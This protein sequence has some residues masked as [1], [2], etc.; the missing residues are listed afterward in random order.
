MA[1]VCS[2]SLG[3]SYQFMLANKLETAMWL[4]QLFTVCCTV[5]LILPFLG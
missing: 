2:G 5:L 1:D 4:S 3:T